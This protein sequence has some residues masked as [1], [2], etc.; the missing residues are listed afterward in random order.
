MRNLSLFIKP[1]LGL[2]LPELI[3]KLKEFGIEEIEVPVRKG[4]PINPENCEKELPA[5]QKTLNGEG[6]TIKAVAGAPD[7]SVFSA[8]QSSGIELLRVMLSISHDEEYFDAED[9]FVKNLSAASLLCEKYNTKVGIQPHVGNYIAHVMELRHLLER[10]DKRYIGA[11]WD[12]AHAGLAGELPRKSIDIIFDYLFLVNLKS[13][14]FRKTEE[15]GKQV[16]LPYYTIGKDS[17]CSWKESIDYLKEKGYKG[18]FCSH[19]EYT[20]PTLLNRY[21]NGEE[22]EPLFRADCEYLKEIL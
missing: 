18:G 7:E 3:K 11:V 19:A 4:L 16:H 2:P 20:H 17:P 1:W 6:I 15:D 21:T 10:C 13:A 12:L 5:L 9:R 14:Y 22:S 8:M